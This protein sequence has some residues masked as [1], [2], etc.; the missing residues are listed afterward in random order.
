MNPEVGDRIVYEGRTGTVVQVRRF[1]DGRGR[2]L[3]VA[4]DCRAGE[5]PTR[6]WI[7]LRAW[8]DLEILPRAG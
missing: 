5:P 6:E 3:V 8:E 7:E 4:Y 2:W 1:E